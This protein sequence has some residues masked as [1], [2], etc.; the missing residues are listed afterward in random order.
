MNRSSKLIAG[1]FLCL[2]LISLFPFAIRQVSV[3]GRD[4]GGS[5]MR[6]TEDTT[7][8]VFNDGRMETVGGSGVEFVSLNTDMTAYEPAPRS[9]GSVEDIPV[10]IVKT[11]DGSLREE[12]PLSAEEGDFVTITY[13]T[14]GT[15]SITSD[16]TWLTEDGGRIEFIRMSRAAYEAQTGTVRT[17]LETIPVEIA[18]VE[19]NNNGLDVSTLSNGCTDYQAISYF[20]RGSSLRRI[21]DYCVNSTQNEIVKQYRLKNLGSVDSTILN[22]VLLTRVCP[23][24]GVTTVVWESSGGPWMIAPGA[25]LAFTPWV[26]L[27]TGSGQGGVYESWLNETD[28]QSCF[29]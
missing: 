29:G 25:T 24:G 1:S 28:T 20:T 6:I 5:V 3:E 16:G 19:G 26:E 17:E 15:L 12:P 14:G 13:I 27:P 23:P 9:M 22:K 2:A 18:P 10:T 21:I 7:L 11:A 8:H 4:N